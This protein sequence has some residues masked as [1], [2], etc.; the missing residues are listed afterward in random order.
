MTEAAITSCFRRKNE[1][2]VLNYQKKG[3]GKVDY[4]LERSMDNKIKK[5]PSRWYEKQIEVE[6]IRLDLSPLPRSR[7]L[8]TPK[9][10]TEPPELQYL[11]N[12]NLKEQK[13]FLLILEFVSVY[14]MNF[15]A[16]C[17]LLAPGGSVFFQSYILVN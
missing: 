13:P 7:I 8:K 2:K 9:Y 10:F 14:R 15:K 1:Y 16:I 5:P 6:P 3:K 17:A 4:V 12:S 11:W